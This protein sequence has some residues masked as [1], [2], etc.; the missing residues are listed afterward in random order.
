[1]QIEEKVKSK[2]KIDWQK[3]LTEQERSGLSQAEYCRQHHIS[4][5]K[6]SYH[7]C[8]FKVREKSSNNSARFKPIKISSLPPT[9][10]GIK[11]ILP[12]GFQCEFSSRTDVLQIKKLIEVLLSC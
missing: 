12:N 10:D 4:A 2:T 7:R 6:L 8:R 9:S 5:A 11:L 1:M 3:I